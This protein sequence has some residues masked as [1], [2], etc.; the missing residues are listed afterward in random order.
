MFYFNFLNTYDLLYFNVI[1]AKT[2]L[3]NEIPN[4]ICLNANTTNL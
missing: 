3:L 2:I 1:I 4:N